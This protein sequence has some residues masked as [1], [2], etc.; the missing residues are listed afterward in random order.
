MMRVSTLA[1]GTW[2]LAVRLRALAYLLV[3]ASCLLPSVQAAEETGVQARMRKDLTYLASDECEGR[4]V[5]TQGINRAATHIANEFKK[6]GLKP[7]GKDG[8]YFQ[9][10]TIN[11]GTLEAP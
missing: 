7:A 3:T 10:F 6:A 5:N 8:S 4:G 9:S 1:F 11:G 2:H